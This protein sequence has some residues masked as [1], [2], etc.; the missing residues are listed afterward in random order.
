MT[1]VCYGVDSGSL[2]MLRWLQVRIK[3]VVLPSLVWTLRR[4]VMVFVCTWNSSILFVV[5][6]VLVGIGCRACSV[7]DY[8]SLALFALF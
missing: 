8:S 5:L 3:S 4:P 1:C 6:G 7:V 2:I